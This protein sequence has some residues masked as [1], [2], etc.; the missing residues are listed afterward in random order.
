MLNFIIASLKISN[1]SDY[2]AVAGQE[3]SKA[4]K[5]RKYL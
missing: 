1:L 4:D 5:L 2:F 3:R